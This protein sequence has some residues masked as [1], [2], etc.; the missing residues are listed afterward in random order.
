MSVD[1]RKVPLES[2]HL[3]AEWIPMQS[4][5]FLSNG[6]NTTFHILDIYTE[7]VIS[8]PIP[9]MN[10]F[11]TKWSPDGSQALTLQI[12]FKNK[13]R[14]NSLIVVNRYGELIKTIIDFTLDKINPVGWSGLQS[15]H[16]LLNNELNSVSINKNK[17]EWQFPISYAIGNKLFRKVNLSSVELLRETATVILNLSTSYSSSLIAFEE[18]GGNLWVMDPSTKFLKE[19]GPGNAP[20]ISPNGFF[21]L[22]MVLEDDGYQLTKGEIYIWDKKADQISQLTY[23]ENQIEMNPS[24]STD[25]KY[26][27]A[28]IYPEGTLLIGTVQ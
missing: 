11:G 3:N 18:Y 15:I 8:S 7:K 5:L 28:T 23:S 6:N 4:E 22:F 9:N 14:F 24:I 20:A 21:I 19:I 1:W 12:K 27:S 10:T 2:S 13:R 16:Y 25:G 26:I 17:I